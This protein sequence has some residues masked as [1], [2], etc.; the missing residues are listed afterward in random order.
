MDWNEEPIV[1]LSSS[2]LQQQST[3]RQNL[4]IQIALIF[5]CKMNVFNL[6]SHVE[7]TLIAM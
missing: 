6:H 7:M 3:K 2:G 5:V 1:I 4:Y